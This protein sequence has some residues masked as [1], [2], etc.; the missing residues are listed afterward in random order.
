MPMVMTTRGVIFLEGASSDAS[1]GVPLVP[2]AST[3]DEDGTDDTTSEDD[4]PGQEDGKERGGGRADAV[5]T[6]LAAFRRWA[7]KNR[8]PRRPFEFQTVTKADAPDLVFD[9]RVVFASPGGDPGPKGEPVAWPGWDRDQ[10]TAAVWETRLKRAMG[11]AVDCDALAE[12]WL[13]QE[14]VKADEPDTATAEAPEQQPEDS[15]TGEW[16]AAIAVAFLLAEGVALTAPLAAVLAGIW[17]EGWAI[18]SAA[19]HSILAGSR[20]RYGWKIGDEAAARRTLTAAMV[21]ALTAFVDQHRTTIPVIAD[22]R[23]QVFARVLA[24]AKARGLTVKQ[25]A[26]ALRDALQDDAWARM[27]AL[28]ELT[29]ASAA[30]ARTAYTAAGITTWRWMTEPDACPVCVANEAAGPRVIGEVWPDG[31]AAPPAHP[32]CRCSVLPLDSPS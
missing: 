32:H 23:L 25:L 18:G 1:P 24:D 11:R 10:T 21:D 17:A 29:R 6:E 8:S 12:R 22:R 19:A 16:A 15:N 26:D 7:K 28:T 3:D 30:A 27:V 9:E 31:S 13:A 4:E 20:A 14:L 2:G 5:K